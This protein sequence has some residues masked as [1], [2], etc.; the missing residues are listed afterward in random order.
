MIPQVISRYVERL[1]LTPHTRRTPTLGWFVFSRTAATL[2]FPNPPLMRT[3]LSFTASLWSIGLFSP[4]K[5]EK[6]TD[7]ASPP[8]YPS[9]SPARSV[10]L[11]VPGDPGQSTNS[12]GAEHTS[13]SLRP[14]CLRTT[15]GPF[16]RCT[17]GNVRLC[18][19]PW[20]A[21]TLTIYA[22]SLTR[23]RTRDSDEPDLYVN[24]T[25]AD[26]IR[27]VENMDDCVNMLD[28][29]TSKV[30]IPWMIECVTHCAVRGPALT[31]QFQTNRRR[32]ARGRINS[33]Y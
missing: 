15:R 22:A 27:T 8:R 4:S 10:L 14:A 12:N 3:P 28:L 21:P 16:G 11:S 13:D 31:A 7:S 18:R 25:M 33:I 24:G 5:W 9:V 23:Q 26:F 2:P 19:S 29:P 6:P 17:V 20:V 30:E 1:S 32:S